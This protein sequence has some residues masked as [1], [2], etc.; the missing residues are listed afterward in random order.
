MKRIIISL[1]IVVATLSV[2]AQKV[3][4]AAAANLRYVLEEIKTAYVKQNPKAKVN[5]TF[6]ASGF[7]RFVYG[8]RQRVS[9]EIKGKRTYIR[10]YVD[11]CS[12]ETGNVQHD[13][14]YR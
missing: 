7:I 5:L 1:A 8:C 4:I 9:F 10:S 11:L 3:N 12:W 6:G 14:E 13:P 2:S